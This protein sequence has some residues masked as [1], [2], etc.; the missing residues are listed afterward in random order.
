MK[1]SSFSN[2]PAINQTPSPSRANGAQP[3]VNGQPQGSAQVAIS[4]SS[5]QM[6]AQQDGDIDMARVDALRDAI[7][8]G[9]LRIDT[10][11]IADGLLASARELLD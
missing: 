5:L 6:L 10:S 9:K 11:R 1:I 7:A 3:G 4:A 8:S 2:R